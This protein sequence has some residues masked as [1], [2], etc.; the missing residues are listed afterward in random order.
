[1]RVSRKKVRLYFQIRVVNDK[2]KALERAFL[3]EPGLDGRN[4]FKHVVF[5]PGLWTGYS[6]ATY[7]GLVESFDAGD[8]A[9]AQVRKK[10]LC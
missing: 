10:G 7:P 2:Y 3:Y 1:M 6:G 8:S 5:A 4:W 9:N